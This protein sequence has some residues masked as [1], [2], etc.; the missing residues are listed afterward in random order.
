M[1]KCKLC[2]PEKEVIVK[3]KDSNTTG[4]IRHL[5]DKHPEIYKKTYP[6]KELALGSKKEVN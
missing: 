2:S 6:D 3:M 1:G 4:V 5:R